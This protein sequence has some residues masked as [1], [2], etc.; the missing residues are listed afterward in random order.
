MIPKSKIEESCDRTCNEGYGLKIHN[1]TL[2]RSLFKAGVS[3]AEKELENLAIEFTEWILQNNAP[4]F[5]I[6]DGDGLPNKWGS[7]RQGCG[8][9]TTKELF[10]MFKQDKYGK[11]ISNNTSNI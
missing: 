6:V 11:K 4:G 7:S 1:D 8:Y 10:E 2:K 3:F 5:K 9:K